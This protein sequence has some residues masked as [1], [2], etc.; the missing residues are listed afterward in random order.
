MRY[1][2][3][4][5]VLV[6]LGILIALSINNWNEEKKLLLNEGA[7]YKKLISDL[8]TESSTLEYQIG[9]AK[10][11]QD[12]HYAI[13][14]NIKRKF[15]NDSL[16]SYN[17]LQWT[18][19]YHPKITKIYTEKLSDISNEN[20]RDL[21]RKYISMENS[22][23]LAIEDFNYYKIQSVRPFIERNGLYNIE[24]IFNNQN[25]VYPSSDRLEFI[26]G[27]KL[28]QHFGSNELNSILVEL[29][30][31]MGWLIQNFHDLK[32]FNQKLVIALD[33]EIMKE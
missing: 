18:I 13:Y 8:T 30:L 27:V 11:D 19:T 3:G 32:E 5:I 29:R 10:R 7:L 23:S 4:E 15:N 24:L 28:E 6:V 22:T 17:P 1:A 25:Y 21:I 31:H 9:L 20:V 14:N 2:I 12:L 33:N 26:N 16:I